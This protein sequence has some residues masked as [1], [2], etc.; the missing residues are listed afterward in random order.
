MPPDHELNRMY[1]QKKYMAGIQDDIR[2]VL[3]DKMQES[4]EGKK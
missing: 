3:M 1:K 2:E 4:F